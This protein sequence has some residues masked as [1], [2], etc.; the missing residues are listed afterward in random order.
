M[1]VH[2]PMVHAVR[3]GDLGAARLAVRDHHAAMT[4]HLGA[5]HAVE[6]PAAAH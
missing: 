1:T 6:Q 5:S 2:E 3:D 4:E